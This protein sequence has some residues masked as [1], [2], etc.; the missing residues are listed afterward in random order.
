MV[1]LR[2]F[3]VVFSKYRYGVTAHRRISTAFGICTATSSIFMNAFQLDIGLFVLEP[4]KVD[5]D[6]AICKC[7]KTQNACL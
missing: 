3:H 6:T 5:N 2:S 1:R 4:E 7:T